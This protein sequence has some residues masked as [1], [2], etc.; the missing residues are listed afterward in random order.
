[1]ISFLLVFLLGSVIIYIFWIILKP[2]EKY[3]TP[4]VL[5]KK[6]DDKNKPE[7]KQENQNLNIDPIRKKIT[8]QMKKDP[9][10]ISRALSYWL[11][12]K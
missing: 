2:G 8:E 7:K 12:Q 6:I 5:R 10:I 9:E 4:K 1:M 11:N 3:T